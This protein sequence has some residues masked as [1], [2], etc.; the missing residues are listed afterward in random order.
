[1]ESARLNDRSTAT[2]RSPINWGLLGLLIQRPSYGYE[3]VQRFE[4][5]YGD[6]L[7]LSSRSQIY[8]ALDSLARRGL[9][10]HAQDARVGDPVRQPKLHYRATEAG[11]RVYE[12]WL[13]EQVSDDE[14]RSRLIAQHVAA[15]P[16]EHAQRVL[17]R[18]AVLCLDAAGR[19]TAE[20]DEHRSENPGAL[21]ERLAG[22]EE[23]LH[24][25]ATLS[26]I[27]YAR[28]ELRAAASRTRR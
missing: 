14:R 19:L 3:L 6:T 1:M 2:M 26:W 7:E 17:E 28:S 10:E 12:R 5:T 11:I 22:E 4:R 25:G 8:T 13:V 15:L 24:A 21:V 27:E 18:C 16:L 23:R 9:I 20:D